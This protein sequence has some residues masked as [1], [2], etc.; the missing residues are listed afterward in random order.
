VLNASL[1]TAVAGGVFALILLFSHYR[2]F[3]FVTRAVEAVQAS[4]SAKCLI[5][6]PLSEKEKKPK[7]YYGIA[8]ASGTLYTMW[9]KV[10]H[11]GFPL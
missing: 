4:L 8:I 6:I 9:W 7:L 1:F 10:S 5:R 2:N 3:R 11:T